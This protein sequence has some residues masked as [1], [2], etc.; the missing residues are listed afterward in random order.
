MKKTL[1]KKDRFFK[2]PK[3]YLGAVAIAMASGIWQPATASLLKTTEFKV[4]HLAAIVLKGNIKDASNGQTLPGVSI[5]VKGTSTGTVTDANGNFSIKVN[6]T[7]VLQFSYIG[8]DAIEIPVKGKSYFDVKLQPSVAKNINEVIVVGYGTQKKTSTTAAVS[9]INTQEIAQKPV[10]NVTN[11]LVGRASG[12]IITQSSG[13]PGYDGSSIQIRGTSSIGRSNPLTIVDGVPRDFS[14]IDPNSIAT[15]SI[16]KDAAAVAPYGV[17]GAN[18]VILITTKQGK[19]GKASLTYNGYFGVQNPTKVPK[20]VNSYEYALMRNEANANDAH[21]Q[22]STYQPFATAAD[23]QKYQDHSDPDGHPDGHPLQDIIKSN[24]PITNHNIT[25]SG[26]NDDVKYFASVA[27]TH[28]AGMW[29]PTYL[30]KYNGALS[31]TAKA[32]STTNVG[33]S[34][35]SSVEDQHFPAF[36]AGTIIDQA[37]RQAPTTPVY[38]S[39]GLWSGYIG[40]SLIGE[41]YHSGYQTNHNTVLYSQLYIDQKLPIDGLSIKGVVS[42]DSGPDPLF[43]GNIT[44]FSRRYAT[45]VPFYNVNTTTTPYTYTANVQGNSKASFSEGYAQNIS[46]TYQ[47]LLNYAHNFGKSAVTG[48]VVFEYRNVNYQTFG[49]QRINYNLNIDE[50]NFG[51]PAPSDATNS[52][53]SSGQKQIGYVYRLGYTYDNRYLFEAA[54]RYDGSYLFGPNHRFGFFPAFSAGWRISQEKF[55]KDITWI[56][57]L[58]LRASWG[59]SGAYPSVSGNIQTYQYLSPYNA[60]GNSAVIG[61]SATQGIYEALQGN[62]NITW[63]KANKTDVGFEASLWKGALGI[64]A[65]YFYEKRSNMLV[66]IG[67]SLP[68]EYGIGVGLINGGIMQNKGIDLTLTT[69]KQFNNDLR[70][71]VKGT[72]TYAKNK[73]L[74]VYEN[75]ATFNNPNRRQTGRPLG[76]QFGLKALGYFTPAD[77]VD[78][79][80]ASPVLKQGIPVPSFGTVRPGDIKYADLNNDGKIDANDI[81]DIGHPSTPGIIYGLEP[82]VT[83]K[84]FDIDLLFQ[85]SGLSTNYF[86][87]YFVWPFQASGSATELVYKDHWTPTNTDALYPRLTGTPT[88]NNT[89]KSTWWMRNTSYLRLR[90]FEVG[91]TFSNKLLGRTIKSLRVFAAGQNLFTWTPSIKE[92][93]DPEQGGNNQNYFQ[94]RVISF[95]VNA[96]F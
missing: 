77:F 14:R 53:Y 93:Y 95:G 23:L 25:L 22:G 59:Q 27:Y 32:T 12:L 85:G 62:P 26:G 60:Y 3:L 73:L 70:L 67:N 81:T 44:T 6:E 16:L 11:S 88:S 18:G 51:G 61:G 24:R 8:Y 63:E 87:N 71:D 38:Y 43:G 1:L 92:T 72:F 57:N 36:S 13:E 30:N 21:D 20:F 37:M 68:A 7:D 94:Q 2:R 55:M 50:L 28:Q 4:N 54:G 33:I 80:A 45:P 17:A 58:K 41:I 65:D 48:L 76:E 46:L 47:G 86:N 74:Q 82:R 42:Y 19:Q 75:S 34:V 39:N 96:T 29:D 15:I 35:N 79:N 40:Q 10:V 66:G 90:S 52:G 31:V 9:T 84:N 64:E 69:F 78:P 91:Y 56:D 83:Y 5:K 49:A 89:Q